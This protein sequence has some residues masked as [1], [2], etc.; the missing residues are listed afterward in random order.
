MAEDEVSEQEQL[1]DAL[2]QRGEQL[3][4][5]LR[6]INAGVVV[7]DGSGS[8]VMLNN[9]GKTRL[10]LSYSPELTLADFA[11]Q[12]DWRDQDGIPFTKESFP[13][14]DVLSTGAPIKELPVSRGE[15]D[16]A[17]H[18]SLS[19]TPLTGRDG[20]QIGAVVVF[21]EVTELVRL[22]NELQEMNEQRLGFYSGMSHELRT[23]LQG[24]VGYTDLLL[25]E[26]EEGT[27]EQESLTAIRSSCDHLLSLVTDL[28]DISKIAAGR[29]ELDKSPTEITPIIREAVSM[30]SP[31]AAEKGVTLKTNLADLGTHDVDERAIRQVVLNLISNAIKYTEKEGE[32]V[33][34]C[35]L[36]DDQIHILVRDTG[37]GMSDEDQQVI[38]REFVQ[39]RGADGRQRAGTGLGLALSKQFIEMHGGTLIVTSKVGVGS[40]FI[41]NLPS[42]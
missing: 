26:S 40:T 25:E 3:S 23:P 6:S 24:I 14:S 33:V 9:V 39:V 36:S 27:F 18:F 11:A 28:L 34:S 21:H 17:L 20:S 31:G 30:V 15:G 4:N 10:G 22:Q 1:L 7:V 2:H 32:V 19:A 35:E 5:I 13:V 8:V 38:F 29:M 37:V 41:V 42:E 12:F 16:D